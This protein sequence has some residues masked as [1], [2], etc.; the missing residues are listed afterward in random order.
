MLSPAAHQTGVAIP[1]FQVGAI[2]DIALKPFGIW[3][4]IGGW[5]QEDHAMQHIDFHLANAAEISADGGEAGS[6]REVNSSGFT[7][8]GD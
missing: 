3:R 1:Q 7:P 4:K 5:G 2:E 6:M 8:H